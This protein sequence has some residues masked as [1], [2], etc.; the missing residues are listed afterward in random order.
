M[1][2]PVILLVRIE[3]LEIVHSLPSGNFGKSLGWQDG[4]RDCICVARR[5]DWDEESAYVLPSDII[6]KS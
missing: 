2:C 1:C 3:G 5:Y 6:G 4:C